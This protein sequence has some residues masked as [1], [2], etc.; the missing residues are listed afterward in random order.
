MR[1]ADHLNGLLTYLRQ[2]G[3]GRTVVAER[4]PTVGAPLNQTSELVVK[5]S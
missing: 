5:M 1:N 4:L 3:A 2:N